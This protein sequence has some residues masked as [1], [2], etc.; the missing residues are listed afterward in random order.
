MVS[1][2]H[3]VNHITPG[4]QSLTYFITL[5]LL[6]IPLLISP[7]VLSHRAIC[8]TFFPV[9][10]A[11]LAHA[12]YVM[13]GTDVISTSALLWAIFFWAVKDPRR[14]FRMLVKRKPGR[15][16]VPGTTSS[17]EKKKS[18]PNDSLPKQDQIE[19][20]VV[21]WPQEFRYRL[22]WVTSLLISLRLIDWKINEFSHDKC[23][24][25]HTTGKRHWPFIRDALL[26]AI[27]SYIAL[28]L[29]SSFIQTD[30]YFHDFSISI[31]SPLPLYQNGPTLL[32]AIYNVLPP[33]FLRTVMIA[34]Q[35]Y[36]L[37]SQQFHLPM[38]PLVILHHLDLWPD[39]LSPHLWPTYFGPVTSILDHGLTGFWGKY[40]HQMTRWTFSGPGPSIADFL[41]FKRSSSSHKI[42]NGHANG[43]AGAKTSDKA[44]GAEAK[45]IKIVRFAILTMVAFFNSGLVHAGLVPPEPLRATLSANYI[46][47]LLGGFFWIQ[48]FGIAFEMAASYALASVVRKSWRESQAGRTAKRALNLVWIAVWSCV[49]FPLLGEVARQLRWCGY[50]TVPMSGLKWIRGEEWVM[51]PCLK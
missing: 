8:F 51:W 29:T 37:I 23:Q 41:G 24:P 47:L 39:A 4:P 7:A 45:R 49:A 36:C 27:F 44:V 46:R 15:Q 40:W 25:T 48:P 6:P 2:L 17:S 43:V 20:D 16:H 22:P 5:F 32:T 50:Y 3:L 12:W 18:L 11:C 31:N 1:Y 21:P 9:L 34:T 42:P 13:R 28:D 35:A 38:I 30:A 19:Y 33:L 10:I 26:R 14:E